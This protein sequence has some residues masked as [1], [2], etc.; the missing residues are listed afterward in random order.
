VSAIPFYV[1]TLSAERRGEGYKVTTTYFYVVP[2]KDG[3]VALVRL[4]DGR[5]EETVRRAF[6]AAG[7]RSIAPQ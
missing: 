2:Q 1:T 6:A 7:G 5:V 3:D 4:R